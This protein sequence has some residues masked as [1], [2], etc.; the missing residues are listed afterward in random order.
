M[1]SVM[2]TVS[3]EQQITDMGDGWLK[4]ADISGVNIGVCDT[5]F[6][7]NFVFYETFYKYLI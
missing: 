7:N 3:H 4:T 1:S 2:H 6:E 5:K